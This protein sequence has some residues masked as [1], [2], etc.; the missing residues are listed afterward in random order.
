[1]SAPP[2]LKRLALGERLQDPLL[3][4][5]VEQRVT[6]RGPFTMLTLGN[7][8]GQ[9]STSPFWAE[10]QPR[11]AGIVRG[12]IAQVSGE[13]VQYNGRRQLKVTSLRVLPRGAVDWR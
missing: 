10:D 3:V 2:D 9:L 12:D 8:H 7:C 13:V 4:L 5:G 1:M 11:I 6:S